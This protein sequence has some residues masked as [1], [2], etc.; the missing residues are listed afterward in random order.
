VL[1]AAAAAVLILIA[2]VVAAY[3]L[4]FSGDGDSETPV[5]PDLVD[6]SPTAIAEDACLRLVVTLDFQ[7]VAEQNASVTRSPVRADGC[8]DGEYHEGDSVTLVASGLA[9][10]H[11]VWGSSPEIIDDQFEQSITLNMPAESLFVSVIYYEG[12][13][14]PGAGSA[15]PVA[16]G[17]ATVAPSPSPST[18]GN[19]SATATKPPGQPTA[20]PTKPAPT[21]TTAPPAP[22]ATSTPIPPT[23]T[24]TQPAVGACWRLFINVSFYP[25]ADPE[26][27]YTISR[28][29]LASDGC[30]A[31]QYRQG[32]TIT[33]TASP[34]PGYHPVWGTSPD[35]L[36]AD[37][38]QATAVFTMPGQ[39]VFAGP[40]YF[41]N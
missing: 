26:P 24:P 17:T 10:L 4:F 31:G 20:T 33:L 39:D 22:T 11:P 16:T 29:P 34:V 6:A 27:P 23:P 36:I 7:G 15:S 30:P 8:Q 32:E 3:F 37:V 14:T 41:E 25:D 5:A 13:A 2:G 12:E 28:S 1:L 35:K 9:G 21:A 18:P 19:P 40:T 38:F